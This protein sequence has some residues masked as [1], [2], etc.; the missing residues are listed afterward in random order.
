MKL[1]KKWNVR[2][3]LKTLRIGI[4]IS[5]DKST[6]PVG[7]KLRRLSVI[8]EALGHDRESTTSIYLVSLDTTAV[9]CANRLIIGPL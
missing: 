5:N 8:S 3:N 6:M 1:G 7:T 9:D 4:I 2:K